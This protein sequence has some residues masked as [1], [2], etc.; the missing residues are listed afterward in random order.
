MLLFRG[1]TCSFFPWEDALWQREGSRGL[2][3]L[4][5]GLK[6]LPLTAVC[7][8][9]TTLPLGVSLFPSKDGRQDGDVICGPWELSNFVI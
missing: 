1:R 5:L 8:G 4:E 6:A 7:P 3:A 2:R 9:T